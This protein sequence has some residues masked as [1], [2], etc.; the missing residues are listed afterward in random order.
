MA[1]LG[2]GRVPGSVQLQTKKT[3]PLHV[4][5]ALQ[6]DSRSREMEG[7]VSG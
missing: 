3:H 7:L 2:G 6:C 1:I 5:G 4:V